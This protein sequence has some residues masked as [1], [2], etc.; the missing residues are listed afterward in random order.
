MPIDVRWDNEARDVIRITID[1][2]WT[3]DE[4]FSSLDDERRLHD[5]V[6]HSAAVIVDLSRAG[7]PPKG[8]LT[9]LAKFHRRSPTESRELLVV[10]GA[11]G[12]TKSM[13]QIFAAAFSNHASVE[14]VEDAQALI[15]RRRA[16]AG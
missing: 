4:A 7:D 6:P 9:Q 10:A 16:Q 2:E 5:E 12:L 8:M 13:S 1:G 3:L 14:T 15:A 11:R